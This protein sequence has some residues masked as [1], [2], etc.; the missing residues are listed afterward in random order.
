MVIVSSRQQPVQ[1]AEYNTRPQLSLQHSREKK[2]QTQ[3]KR[4]I[5]DCFTSFYFTFS[6]II[7][8]CCVFTLLSRY[9]NNTPVRQVKSKIKILKSGTNSNKKVP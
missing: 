4:H 6:P 9:W 3:P 2:T 7:S 5:N 1:R 8:D